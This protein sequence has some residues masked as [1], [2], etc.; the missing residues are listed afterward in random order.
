MQLHIDMIRKVIP[1]LAVGLACALAGSAGAQTRPPADTLAPIPLE[2]VTVSVLRT[3]LPLTE[4]PYAVSAVTVDRLTPGRPGLALDEALRAIPG[5][6]IDNRYN[7]ALGERIAIRG[8]GARSQFGIRGVRV[9]VDDVPATFPDGQTSLSHL[10]LGFLSRA[11]IIR[12]P[13]SSLY[14]GSA[15]GVIQLETRL[16]LPGE[17]VR[18]AAV[19]GGSHELL[20]AHG[21]VGQGSDRGAYLVRLS[22]LGYGGEREYN[23]AENLWVHAGGRYEFPFGYLSITATGL[24]YNAQ[25]PGSLSEELLSEDRRQAVANNIRQGAGKEG[26]QYQLGATLNS[27]V[28]PGELEINAYGINREISNPI[29]AT[30]IDLDRDVF[31]VRGLYRVSAEPGSV[32]FGAELAT[33]RD[34]RINF[35]N[36][37]GERGGVTLEQDET[38]DDIALFGQATVRVLGPVTLL[39]GLRYDWYRF[40]AD[41]RLVNEN[42]PDDSG[43]IRMSQASPSLGIS[44]QLAPTVN[45]YGNVATAFETPTTTELANRPEGAGGFNPELRPQET[46]SFE[47]GVKGTLP[48]RFTYELAAYSADVTNALIPFEVADAPDRQFFRNAGEARHQ[49]VEAG[50]GI[51]PHPWVTARAAYTY[52]DARFEDYAVGDERFDDNRIPGVAPHRLEGVLDLHR[53]GPFLTLEGRY[54]SR[55]P[56]DDAN[57]AHSPSYFVADLRTGVRGVEVGGVEMEPTLGV[58]NLFGTDYNSSVT[59]NAFGRR[60]FEP[61]PGRT[62]NVGLRVRF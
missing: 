58:Q 59:V 8:F 57:S 27:P 56:V 35:A 2:E 32:T 36:E 3:P 7:Y 54:M 26:H 39:G 5:V 53:D 48:G 25:N 31:G 55:I 14:G 33:Q 13:A 62:V 49:G 1:L 61:A 34:G 16:P 22:H 20:R 29:P 40:A 45:L 30:I 44:V 46:L 19:M 18:E 21:A 42:D 43:S 12:G 60:Y 51:R 11:E 4:T 15:G 37:Q 10:D 24:E 52:T 47:A 23:D 28:G 17:Q 9:I 6:Q 38:V 41:D 50:V